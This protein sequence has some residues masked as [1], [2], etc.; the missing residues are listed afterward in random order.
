LHTPLQNTDLAQ[1]DRSWQ[2]VWQIW[3]VVLLALTVGAKCVSLAI[4]SPLLAEVDSVTGMSN[5]TIV[6]FGAAVEAMML[7][8]LFSPWRLRRWVRILP[9]VFG[10][11]ALVYHVRSAALG[12]ERCPCLGGLFGANRILTEFEVPFLTAMA[13]F[14]AVSYPIS[15]LAIRKLYHESGN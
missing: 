14:L 6:I 11:I 7:G 8:L 12:M 3:V 9:S 13:L 10:I 4:G 2:T 1:A 15:R 5:R